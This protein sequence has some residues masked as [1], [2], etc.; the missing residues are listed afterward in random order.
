MTLDSW[1]NQTGAEK[2]AKKLKVGTSAVSGWKNK[3][4][5]PRPEH[6]VLIYNLSQGRVNYR[7]MVE[8]YVN[9]QPIK[10]K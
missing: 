3:R 4:R 7:T 6:M 8:G 1:I 9:A 2:I 5:M 10:R